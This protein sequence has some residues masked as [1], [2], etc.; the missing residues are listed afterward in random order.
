MRATGRS[1]YVAIGLSM[2]LALPC[3]AEFNDTL[4]VAVEE[5]SMS[6][7]GWF[8]NSAGDLNDDGYNDIVVEANRSRK[9]YVYSGKT[10]D[11]LYSFN[12]TINNYNS[13]S[14]VSIG[15]DVNNDGYDD[16][17]VGAPDETPPG[18][19]VYSGRTG[20]VLYILNDVTGG[21]N[22]GHTVEYAGDVNNDGRDD[23]IALGGLK[24]AVI[25]SGRTGE[26]LYRY[27]NESGHDLWGVEALL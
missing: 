1:W 15:G 13:T 6:V 26:V 27:T 16:L 11:I 4:F 23:I 8:V 20:E 7:F 2:A 3:A 12:I 10:L 19:Y 21:N 24:E 14:R 5:E 25:F 17:I 18:V 9:V 22:L